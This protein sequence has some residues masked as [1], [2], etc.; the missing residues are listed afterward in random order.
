MVSVFVNEGLIPDKRKGLNLEKLHFRFS[1]RVRWDSFIG[2][3]EEVCTVYLPGSTPL[4]K[5]EEIVRIL[6]PIS[7]FI[8]TGKAYIDAL[9][10]YKKDSLLFSIK[11]FDEVLE[12]LDATYQIFTDSFSQEKR[13]RW[14]SLFNT[15]Y[16]IPNYFRYAAFVSVSFNYDGNAHLLMKVWRDKFKPKTKDTVSFLF[17]D[18]EVK[19]Y[20]IKNKPLKEDDD[21][22]VDIELSQSDLNKLIE[23]PIDTIRFE[24]KAALPFAFSL[25]TRNSLELGQIIFQRFAKRFSEALDEIGIKWETKESKEEIS[26]T[27][28]PCFVYLMVDTTNGYHKIGISN[29]PEYREGTLQSEKPTIELLCAKQFPSRTIA[30][31]IES[32][33]HKT[34]ED[35]HLRG[36]WFQLDAR[37]IIDLMATL[38]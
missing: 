37:D 36:E 19:T 22:I 6:A 4:S 34:Y 8:C 30:K 28:E 35:K 11:P 25:Y 1:S 18:S 33:L 10:L 38:K 29:H 7:G 27:N 23:V 15:P 3:G 24:S 20:I 2:K 21:Y 17:A 14:T 5:S 16:R 26:T 31:A 32:A 12:S 13:I 9:G